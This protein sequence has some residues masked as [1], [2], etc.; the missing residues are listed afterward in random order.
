M[1]EKR[2]LNLIVRFD[3]LVESLDDSAELALLLHSDE[4]KKPSEHLAFP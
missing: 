1:N 2:L 3:L 4:L